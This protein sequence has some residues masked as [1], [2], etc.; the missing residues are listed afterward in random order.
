MRNIQ[1]LICLILFLKIGLK[2]R[3]PRQYK[4]NFASDY[5]MYG[6]YVD[7]AFPTIYKFK[8]VLYLYFISFVDTPL[9][10]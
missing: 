1:I 2:I 7:F 4:N 6:T 3:F 5:L 8:I 9:T 10:M